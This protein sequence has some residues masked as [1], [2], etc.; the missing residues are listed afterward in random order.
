MTKCC[1]LIGPKLDGGKDDLPGVG[2]FW[3][4]S[5][6]R[7]TSLITMVSKP[8]VLFLFYFSLYI[9]ILIQCKHNIIRKN[10]TDCCLQHPWNHGALMG[11]LVRT[12]TVFLVRLFVGVVW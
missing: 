5:Y 9:Y 3:V 6:C 7:N 1:A 12:A 4:L 2:F 10:Y 11:P 8:I